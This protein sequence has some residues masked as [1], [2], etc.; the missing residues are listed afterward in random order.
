MRMEEL[1]RGFWGYQKEGV[2]RC[3]TSMEEEFSARLMEKDAA[4]AKLEEQYQARVREL[5]EA[6]AR[7]QEENRAQSRSQAA[8]SEA[9][10]RA[11]D[12]AQ[13][14]REESQRQ[15][16]TVRR[17][18][19][20]RAHRQQRELDAYQ[21]ELDRLRQTIRTLLEELDSRAGAVQGKLELLRAE[22][23]E[24]PEV[25]RARGEGGGAP[26]GEAHGGWAWGAGS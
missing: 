18:I 1:K 9:L 19:A 23:P 26:A 4:L 11:Q 2:Y 14:L 16:E 24:V 7:A 15:E 12:Y 22:A 21:G 10:L 20:A 6:L 8:I 3:I 13:K 25:P 5:E 17:D